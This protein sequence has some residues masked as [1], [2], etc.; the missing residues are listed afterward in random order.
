MYAAL[1]RAEPALHHANRC[2]ELVRSEPDA[3]DDWDLA[4]A[5]EILA[6]AQL[7]AASRPEAQRN[8]DLARAELAAV[9]DADDRE[10]LA[11]QLAELGLDGA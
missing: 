8:A 11:G 2:L 3:H 10:V 4:S 1:G 6:R 9:S 7:A 5:F